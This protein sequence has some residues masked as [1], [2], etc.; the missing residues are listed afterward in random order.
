MTEHCFGERYRNKST[1]ETLVSFDMFAPNMP[2]FNFEGRQ[3]IGSIFGVFFTC[4]FIVGMSG[5][6]LFNLGKII[7]GANSVYVEI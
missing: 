4:F 6:S 1:Y 2:S 3:K 5:Y 7:D